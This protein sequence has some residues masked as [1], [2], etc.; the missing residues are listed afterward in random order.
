MHLHNVLP[1]GHTYYYCQLHYYY[2]PNLNSKFIIH[3]VSGIQ[4][5]REAWHSS[6]LVPGQPTDQYN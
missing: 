4:D 3:Y 1:P 6:T 2:Y 5:F